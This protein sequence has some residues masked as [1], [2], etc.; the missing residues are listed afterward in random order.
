MKKA[1]IFL[2]FLLVGI[3]YTSFSQAPTKT[4]FFAGK[5]EISVVGTP[6]GDAK[7]VTNLIR[8]DGKLTGELANPADATKEKRPVTKIEENGDNIAIYFTSSQGNDVSIDLARVDGDNLKGSLMNM[9]EAKAKR[10][11]E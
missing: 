9:F 8:K 5:W 2:F 3:A 1:S 4:D 11:K 6:N 10:L 7:M